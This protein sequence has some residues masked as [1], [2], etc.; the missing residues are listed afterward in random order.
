M[1]SLDLYC[2]DG[3]PLESS[4]TRGDVT[5]GHLSESLADQPTRHRREEGDESGEVDGPDWDS[6][7]RRQKQR[8]VPGGFRRLC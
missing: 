4:E 1:K 6:G 2:G 3:G 7:R 8:P 5:D